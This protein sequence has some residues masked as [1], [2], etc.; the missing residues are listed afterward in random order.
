METRELLGGTEENS[1]SPM[2]GFTKRRQKKI[3]LV[4]RPG[5]NDGV[6]IRLV[7]VDPLLLLLTWTMPPHETRPQGLGPLGH[8]STVAAADCQGVFR[9]LLHHGSCGQ[10]HVRLLV[11]EGVP[12]ES[13]AAAWL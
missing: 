13:P 3:E 7:V 12:R 9:Q 2:R 8:P 4:A 11:G 1:V 5:G 10:L 6:L